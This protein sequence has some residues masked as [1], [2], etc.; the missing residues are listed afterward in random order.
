MRSYLV[1][2]LGVVALVILTSATGFYVAESGTNQNVDGFG[3]AVWWAVVTV[4]TIGYGDIFPVTTMGRLVGGFLMFAGIGTLGVFTAAIAAYLIKFDGLD[5]LRTRGLRNHIVICGL[6]TVGTLL[7]LAFRRDGYQVLALEKI[8]DNPRI[9]TAREAGA[10]VLVGDAARPEVLGRARLARARHLVIVAGADANNVEIAAQ[11]RALTR[12]SGHRLPCST[13]IQNPDL[14]YALRSWDIGT[15]DGFRLEFFNVTELGARALL[16]RHSPFTAEQR[17]RSTPPKVL[18]IGASTL[19]QHL[20]RHMVRQWQDIEGT[21]RPRLPIT[22]VDAATEGVHRDL[23]HR[24]PELQSLATLQSLS[25][26]LRSSEFER[27]AFLFDDEGR[28]PLSH[29]YVCLEDEGLALSTAL[30]LMNRVRRFGVPVTV[31]MDREAG[32][33]SLLRAVG[34]A[35]DRTLAQLHVFGLVEQ[36]SQPELVLRGTNEVLARALHQ[37]YLAHASRDH[38]PAAVPWDDLPLELKESNRT[39]ADHIATKLEAVGCHIVPLTALEADSFSFTPA[40]VERLAEMEHERW[41]AERRR[42]GWTL[43]ARNTL[44][45]TNPNLV[46]WA[47]LDEPSREMNRNSV[48]RLPFFLNRAGFTAHR[49]SV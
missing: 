47:E 13:Q 21:T 20:I 11:A 30:L 35:N 4:T 2:V 39:Q 9:A 49:Y 10:A 45:K 37:D 28:C 27:A 33:A 15:R 44:K 34:P 32:L 18:I 26:D 41:L 46:S 31:R 3:D 42:Q 17:E 14:W 16:A 40:E 24:H 38:N 23:H 25:M 1:Y 7:T 43:G 36:A 12:E 48:R 6:G 8:E 19:S 5:A 22:L 29:I